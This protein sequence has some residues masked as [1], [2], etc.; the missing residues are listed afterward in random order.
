[1][2]Y[3]ELAAITDATAIADAAIRA[4]GLVSSDQ[5]ALERITEHLRERH[6]LLVLDN[7][8]HLIDAIATFAIT[9]LHSCPRVTILATSR[10]PMNV[11]GE[12]A[13]RVPP[14]QPDEASRLFIERAIAA[15]STQNAGDETVAHICE[16]LDGMPLAIE[17][18]ASRLQVMSLNDIAAR[19]DDRFNLLAHGRRGALP[20][21]QT[22]RAMID[23]SYELLS[24]EENVAFRRLGVFVG[25]WELDL[26][27][28]LIGNDALLMLT[29]LVSKSLVT[30]DEANGQMGY[31]YLETIRE[32]ALAKLNEAGE[33]Q[34]AQRMHAE[35]MAALI[36][37][38]GKLLRSRDQKHWINRVVLNQANL[39][40]ALTWSFGLEGNTLIGCRITSMDKTFWV[41]PTAT[42]NA[43]HWIS[44]AMTKMTDDM[45]HHIR[46]NLH[47]LHALYFDARGT[48]QE[49]ISEYEKALHLF[50]EVNDGAGIAETTFN[51]ADL[52]LQI[53]MSDRQSLDLLHDSIELAESA[54]DSLIA[55]S[56]SLRVAFWLQNM[57]KLDEADA[58]LHRCIQRARNQN[59]FFNLAG[60]LFQRGHG[61][62][63]QLR[64][65]EA[66]T[67]FEE[68]T[69]IAWQIQGPYSIIRGLGGMAEINRFIGNHTRALELTNELL[70]YAKNNVIDIDHT[71]PI[72]LRAKALNDAGYHNEAF[73]LLIERINYFKQNNAFD[74]VGYLDLFDALACIYAGLGNARQSA[75]VSGA[76][77][78]CLL[79]SSRPRLTHN[80]WEYAPYIAK[81]RA[82]LGD[83][84]YEAARAKGRAMSLDEAIAFVLER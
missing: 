58:L 66:L 76:A 10:E 7:C 39:F 29:Q 51:I 59:D 50:R 71:W 53:N 72:I 16:R 3:V 79:S 30:V 41:N 75:Y 31:R 56:A 19:L 43:E 18:A 21:H 28:S 4:L 48:H 78:S 55:N 57:M 24:E 49:V 22:L 32:Y 12:R 52:H 20:R 46:A 84:V 40:A 6:A 1:V 36:E 27:E 61:F 42:L 81:A 68:A 62:A 64:F 54:G 69:D 13:W 73:D 35:A 2:W 8:E 80:E 47:I 11:E 33:M 65:A 70:A 63:V 5:P 37:H 82:A 17:L 14:M 67:C 26:A 23:W 34:A 77:D 15:R 74:P 45:S 60:M 83:E 44:V 38:A 25:G 9:V